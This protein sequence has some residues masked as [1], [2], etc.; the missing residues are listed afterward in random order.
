VSKK[1]TDEARALLEDSLASQ[2]RTNTRDGDDF[3]LTSIRDAL[4]EPTEEMEWLID[5][6]LSVGG[7]SMWLAKPFVG[8]STTVRAAALKVSRGERF[9]GR[10]TNKVA[11]GYFAL[12]ERRSEVIAHFKKMGATGGE[13]LYLHTGLV[14]AQD[15]AAKL[16]NVIVENNLKFAVIDPIVLMLIRGVSDFNEYAAVYAALE[17]LISIA[18]DTG[19]HLALVHHMSKADRDG[20]DQSMGS[21]AFAAAADT[22]VI[23]RS[24]DGPKEGGVKYRT[25]E[26]QQRRAGVNMPP[27]TLTLDLVTGVVDIGDPA[28]VT[29]KNV[30]FDAVLEF[31]RQ[32]SSERSLLRAEIFSKVELRRSAVVA[33]LKRGVE[34]KRIERIGSGKKDDPFKYRVIIGGTLTPPKLTVVPSKKRKFGK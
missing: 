8:K 23:M 22:L 2:A 25:I 13:A 18:R 19:C 21:T 11:T 24:K 26:T 34:E 31:L 17:P 20:M 1:L 12:E 27:T 3:A 10:A 30:A 32:Q 28:W 14:P 29:K 5:D 16:R 4:A 33:A 7:I 15:V 9:L 6:L